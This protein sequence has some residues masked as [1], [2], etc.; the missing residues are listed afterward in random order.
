M[1]RAARVTSDGSASSSAR[2]ARIASIARSTCPAAPSSRPSRSS[3]SSGGT[4]TAAIPAR[5][6]GIDG[7]S[8]TTGAPHSRAMRAR[9][10]PAV[11][12]TS[13]APAPTAPCTAAIVSSVL[14]ENDIAITRVSG[15]TN[16]GHSYC[17][18]TTIGTGHGAGRPR[19]PRH[20]RCRCRPCP[21]RPPRRC[22]PPVA[23]PRPRPLPTAPR[24]S[25]RAAPEQPRP[26]PACRSRVG[27]GQ[28]T[29]KVGS[30]P[31]AA[32]LAVRRSA[33][34]SST[35]VASS[36]SITGMPSRTS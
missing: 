3:T 17:L 19:R 5:G 20:R 22:R 2:R 34:A 29:E 16:P 1:R 30:T 35:A 31:S 36:I 14:P 23:D 33:S 7:S 8:R 12:A 21:A 4:D 27:A 25:V 18:L 26:S 10:P 15:P 32:A 13:R 28:S 6:M 11:T 24:A 9:C